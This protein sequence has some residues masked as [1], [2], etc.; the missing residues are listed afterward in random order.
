MPARW[1]FFL[2]WRR[3]VRRRRD[4]HQWLWAMRHQWGRRITTEAENVTE[5]SALLGL[6]WMTSRCLIAD[7]PW[8]ILERCRCPATGLRR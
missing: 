3:D 7:G 2:R 4:D 8:E 1:Q 5:L 6:S